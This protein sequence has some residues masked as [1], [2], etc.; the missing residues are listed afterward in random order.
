MSMAK[1]LLAKCEK[2][3][4]E[5]VGGAERR[6]GPTSQ[7]QNKP[8]RETPPPLQGTSPFR[9]GFSPL[10]NSDAMS[11]HT[12]TLLK[13]FAPLRETNIL[14]PPIPVPCK[15][16][17]TGQV[18]SAAPACPSALAIPLPFP[19]PAPPPLRKSLAT[20]YRQGRVPPRLVHRRSGPWHRV[21]ARLP[22][23]A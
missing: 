16:P 2:S 4:P 21:Y 5:R 20:Q 18:Q 12:N 11:S 1:V 23:S 14:P 7:Q 17:P 9:G 19:L 3:S 13:I 22:P 15:N 10:Q 6:R 8:H